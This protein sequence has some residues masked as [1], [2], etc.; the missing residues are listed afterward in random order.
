MAAPRASAHS[1]AVKQPACCKAIA[2]ARACASQ[3]SANKGSFSARRMGCSAASAQAL[4]GWLKIALPQIEMDAVARVGALAPQLGR[5]E[6]HRIEVLR[7]VALAVRA[8][9]G[10]HMS[11]VVADDVAHLAAGIARQ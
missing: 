7:H 3:G 8:G 6:A 2:K 9:V 11:A 1:T 4:S 5:R 10:Q